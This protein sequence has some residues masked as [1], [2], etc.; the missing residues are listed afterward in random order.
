[1]AHIRLGT[2]VGSKLPTL[3][4]IPMAHSR[5]GTTVGSKLPTLLGYE[6]GLSTHRALFGWR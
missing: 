6:Q 1:M 4:A 2:V 3:P 5:L